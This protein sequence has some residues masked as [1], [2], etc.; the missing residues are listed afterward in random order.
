[1]ADS[2]NFKL[3]TADYLSIKH[4]A[5][6]DDMLALA[7][8]KPSEY[9]QLRKNVLAAVKRK[10]VANIYAIYYDL[11]TEGKDGSDTHNKLL[12]G[13]FA[14]G[15]AGDTVN[16]FVP[17]YPKQKVNEFALGAAETID[18]I[19][20]DAIEILLPRG[21]EDIAKERSSTKGKAA[22]IN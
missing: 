17:N 20:E 10:A 7:L 22:M 9:F 21:Y 2:T 8:S 18:K 1:M 12:V 5:F 11:L 13:E 15:L 4:S 16:A 14:A 19:A 6:R 3:D